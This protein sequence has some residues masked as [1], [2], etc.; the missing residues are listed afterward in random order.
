MRHGPGLIGLFRGQLAH[1]GMVLDHEPL[2]AHFLGGQKAALAVAADAAPRLLRQ[3]ESDGAAMPH[4]PV[5]DG[6]GEQ[7]GDVVLG[8]PIG[9]H[10]LTLLHHGLLDDDA[11]HPARILRNGNGATGQ[12]ASH[13]EAIQ[14]RNGLEVG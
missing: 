12:G 7:H 1:H 3:F 5:V 14:A 11:Q 6:T 2:Q 13:L 10:L 8:G 9:F 4:T